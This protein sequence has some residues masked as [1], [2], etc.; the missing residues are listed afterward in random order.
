MGLRNR[1]G[2]DHRIVRI[3]ADHFRLYWSYDK[4]YPNSRL[5]HPR[6]ISRDTD[7]AGAQR[8]AKK[9]NVAPPRATP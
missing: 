2:Y 4:H 5:R 9:W 6:L 3:A 8:F 1:G 7:L